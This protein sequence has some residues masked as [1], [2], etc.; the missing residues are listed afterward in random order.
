ME[1]L[2]MIVNIGLVAW[3]I[4]VILRGFGWFSDFI[5]A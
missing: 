2:L 5:H 3:M 4:S 1:F